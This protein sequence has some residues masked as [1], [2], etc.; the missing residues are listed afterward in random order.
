MTGGKVERLRRRREYKSAYANG[1]KVVGRYVVLFVWNHGEGRSRYGVTATRRFGGA[2][3]RNRARRRLRELARL[4]WQQIDRLEA[5][6]VVNVRRGCQDVAWPELE[7]DYLKCLK[8][9]ASRL[10]ARE[11]S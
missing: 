5:D 3:Q 7:A 2:V 8:R 1:V 6:V 10:P 4:H 9:V 11:P